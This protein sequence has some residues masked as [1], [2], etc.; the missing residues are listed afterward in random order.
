[1]SRRGSIYRR[2]TT[3]GRRSD[4]KRCRCGSDTAWGFTI[5]TAPPGASRNRL[6]RTGFSTK[7]EAQRALTEIQHRCDTGG[8]VDP[9]RLTVGEYLT[10]WLQIR[11][12]QLKPST[13][14]SYRRNID[15][16]VVPAL[17][18]RTL[19][20]LTASDLDHLY[21]NLESNGFKR[22]NI[23]RPLSAKTVRYIHS[24]IRR[25]LK[26]A[27]RKNLISR[28]VAD[29]AD[30]PSPRAARNRYALRTWTPEQVSSFLAA[31]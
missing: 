1:M 11:R 4:T 10:D 17:G 12:S 22:G 8:Y 2:C 25:A 20:S 3:C 23:E 19:Q 30:P 29:A 31:R 21:R 26:D 24:I 5:D 7:A 28:N 18:H 9:S 14:E 27:V 13:W 6:T 15:N 16:H